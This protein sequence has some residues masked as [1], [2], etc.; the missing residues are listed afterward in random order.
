MDNTFRL[1]NN[2]QYYEPIDITIQST[3]ENR[4]TQVMF[5]KGEEILFSLDRKEMELFISKVIK[6]WK[7]KPLQIELKGEKNE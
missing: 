3:H 1:E 7:G 4:S 2:W 6:Q 5:F